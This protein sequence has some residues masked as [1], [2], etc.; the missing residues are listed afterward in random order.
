MNPVEAPQARPAHYLA[1][2]VETVVGRFTMYRLVLLVLSALAAYSLL[3]NVLGW[4][5]FGI[6][7]MLAHLALCL[8]LTYASNRAMAALFRVRPH[9]ESALITGLLLYF[10]FWPSLQ[11]MDLAGV[12]LACI[13]ASASKYTLAWRGRHIFNPAAAGAF[14]TGLTGLNIATWWAATPAMLWLLVPGVLLVLYRT[15]KLLM[16]SL[17]TA[18]A[19]AIIM[20][21]LLRAGMTAGMGAWQALAQ[22]PVLFFVGF[23][24]TEPL[25]LPPRRWQQLA[26]ATLVGVL[27]AV[28]WNLGI[29]AN[30]PEAALLAGNLL[31]FLAGQRGAVKLR[32]AGA[33]PLTPATT[34]FSFEPARPVRFLPGQYM[35]L[36]LPQAKPDGK[37]RRR[38]FSLAGGP[39]GRLV[40]FGVR[41]DGSLSAAKEALLALRPG[42]EVAATAVGG[43][44]VLPRDPRRPVLL[45]AAGIGI[46][47]FISYLASGALQER[48]AVI[49]VLARSNEEVAY[50]EELR[51][52]GVRVLVRLADGSV[53][54]SGL[55]PAAGSLS[56]AGSFGADGRLDGAALAALVPDISR[57]DVYVSGSPASVAALRRAAGRAGAR[58]VRTDSFSGY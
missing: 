40:K 28:P 37:G 34:E 1:G 33:R 50:A 36:D 29:F 42:D 19:T 13:L 43:D 22:R 30:S 51:S 10:L 8:A 57:R 9:T 35:E 5:T 49:L 38:V 47:P 11:S 23:M 41:T 2:R 7:E 17:F 26:L 48:D 3:L 39:G 46:T 20:L 25:T 18:V 14:A 45:V 6:P 52:S 27:F 56:G 53:P 12:A 24:L 15:R 32:F 54:P 21:E 58:R 4:L 16:A 55:A 31:A 44:F